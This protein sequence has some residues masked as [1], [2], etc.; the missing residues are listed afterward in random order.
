MNIVVLNC[1]SSSLKYAL[2]E[3]PEYR[4]ITSGGIERLGTNEAFIKFKSRTGEKVQLDQPIPDHTHGVELVLQVL[5]HPEHGVLSS[6]EEIDAVGHR[7]VHGGDV[8]SGSVPITDE[9][10]AQLEKCSQLAPLHNPANILG[11]RAAQKA[12][13]LVPQAGVFDTAFH[14]TMPEHAYLYALP[15]ELYE[16][17]RIR[18]YGFHGTSHNYVSQRG[19][20]VAGLDINHSKIITAHIGSG[21]S[22]AA[23]LNGKSIDTSMGMTPCEGLV[24]GTRSGDIDPGL[25]D[26]LLSKNDFKPEEIADYIQ[27]KERK[28]KATSLTL[29][30]LNFM[31]NKRS[32]VFGVGG[33]GSSD[34]RDIDAAMHQGN[35]RAQLAYDILIYRIKKYIGAY[36]AALSGVDLIVF[37]AGMG[38]NQAS[39][40]WDA[41]QGLEFLG[42][43]LDPELNQKMR[44]G[45]EGLIST[46]DSRVRVAIIPTDEEYMIAK[47][48]YEIVS[49]GI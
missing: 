16:Q 49:A 47:D 38:E 26:Y 10:I 3:L 6:V 21:A 42:V 37:T 39:L 25:I 1:G 27:D 45:A 30:D 11:I 24:M 48:T 14:Q 5:T 32:G 36:A 12:L 8:F 35:H 4:V 18:R 40:R 7:L 9:V 15:Y 44:L 20:E 46:P 43:K 2:I 31:L 13:P 34:M 22:M 29:A 19:A 23:V 17:H 33:I 41:C 28:G